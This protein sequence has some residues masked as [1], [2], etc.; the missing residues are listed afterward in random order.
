MLLVTAAGLVLVAAHDPP[1]L[2]RLAFAAP[3]FLAGL[4]LFQAQAS[5]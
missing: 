4:G 2:A 3:L 1:R 5:T